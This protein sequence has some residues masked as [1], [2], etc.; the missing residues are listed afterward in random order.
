MSKKTALLFLH[1]KKDATLLKSKQD[2]VNPFGPHSLAL[3]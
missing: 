1:K 3:I 2:Y